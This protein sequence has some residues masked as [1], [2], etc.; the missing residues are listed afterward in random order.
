[1]TPQSLDLTPP[2]FLTSGIFKKTMC[3][4]NLHA[5]EASK[6]NNE[7]Y[8][9]GITEE[10]LYCT[11]CIPFHFCC[12]DTTPYTSRISS[13]VVSVVVVVVIVILLLLLL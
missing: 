8:N 2:D 10:A 6:Q 11:A 13:L 4:K 9:S 5:F 3:T 7:L 1:V 12:T